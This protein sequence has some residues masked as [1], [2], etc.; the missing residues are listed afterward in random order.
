MA[1]ARA[2]WAASKRYLFAS[3]FLPKTIFKIPFLL[4]PFPTVQRCIEAA[5]LNQD[6]TTCFLNRGIYR[7]NL[8]IDDIDNLKIVARDGSTVIFDG[9]LEV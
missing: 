8:H 9:S 3:I 2:G 4:Q 1:A 7:E 5:K 6:H